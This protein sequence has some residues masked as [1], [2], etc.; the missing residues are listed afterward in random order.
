MRSVK[1]FSGDSSY[2]IQ[3]QDRALT[4][5]SNFILD[6][7]LQRYSITYFLTN[8]SRLHL[9]NLSFISTDTPDTPCD[10][11]PDWNLK[12]VSEFSYP[13]TSMPS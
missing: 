10:R 4:F 9:S 1:L 5:Q 2:S 12:M 3:V 6:V 7:I 13:A 11:T 8:I